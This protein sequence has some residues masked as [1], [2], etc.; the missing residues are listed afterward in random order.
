MRRSIPMVFL[1]ASCA[2]AGTIIPVDQAWDLPAPPAGEGVQVTIGPFDVPA[3]SE[4]QKNFFMKL[5]VD[6]DVMV[7]RVQIGY[8][9]G[10]HHLNLFKTGLTFPD[11]VEDTFDAVPYDKFDMFA[12]SQSGS[13]DW[14]MPAGVAL[15][16]AANQQLIAQTHWVN[17]FT[18]STPGGKGVAKVN[19][20]FAKPENVQNTL[21]MMF[22]INKNLDIPPH[23]ESLAQKSVDLARAGMAA[24]VKVVAM[25]GHFHSRGKAFSVD[26]DSGENLYK[27]NN[28]DEPPFKRFDDPI[29]IKNGEKLHYTSTFVNNTDL[30]IKFGPHVENQEHSNFFLYFYPGPA[31][32]KALYDTAGLP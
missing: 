4:V 22:V 31:N 30:L 18:Q 17:G 14:A 5:P 15:K 28:W 21:G 20:W 8:P 6:H 10:S 7:N 25:T 9:K 3:N 29:T 32:G 16:L 27:S 23:R 26:R 12:S 13:L 1:L 2:P 11:H 24:D 19:L